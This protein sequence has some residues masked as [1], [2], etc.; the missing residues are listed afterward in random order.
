[1]KNKILGICFIICPG[2]HSIFFVN[3]TSITVIIPG[4]AVPMDNIDPGY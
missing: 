3:E 2:Q 4:E 1:M